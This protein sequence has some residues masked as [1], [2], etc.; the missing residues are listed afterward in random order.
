MKLKIASAFPLLAALATAF[1]LTGCVTS[2]MPVGDKIPALDPKAWNAKW[3]AGDGTV[4]STHVKDA[5]FGLVEVTHLKAW[6]KPSPGDPQRDEV[7]IRMLGDWTIANS[8]TDGGYNFERINLDAN[9]LVGFAADDTVFKTL[10]RRG[11]LPGRTAAKSNTCIIDHLNSRDITRL[12]A[13][14]IDIHT[15]FGENPGTVM[16]R[17]RRPW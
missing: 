7:L 2:R 8:P 3:R 13:A 16:I 14:G 15:L 4:M 10:I 12:K 1:S 9:G 17:D 5:K 6:T 11:L